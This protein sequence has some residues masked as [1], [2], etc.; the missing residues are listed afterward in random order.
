MNR[1]VLAS[2]PYDK[3]VTI[4]YGRLCKGAGLPSPKSW[5]SLLVPEP[6]GKPTGMDRLRLAYLFLFCHIKTR[7][8]EDPGQTLLFL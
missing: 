1:V 2:L 3:S 8:V 5:I 4:L 7:L 6:A